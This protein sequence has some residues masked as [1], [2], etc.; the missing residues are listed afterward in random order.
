MRPIGGNDV[1]AAQLQE[2]LRLSRKES[3]TIRMVPFSVE[4]ALSNNAAFDLL[5]LGADDDEN[6][7]MYRET[8]VS[9]EIVE[10]RVMATRHRARYEKLWQAA[11][12]EADTAAFIEKR[13]DTL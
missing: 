11:M 1:F 7:V 3:T 8:G 4:A 12:D 10:D 13:L 6:A 2:L 5:Y 9:D